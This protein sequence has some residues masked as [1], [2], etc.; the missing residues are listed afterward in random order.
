VADDQTLYYDDIVHNWGV[1]ERHIVSKICGSKGEST[2]DHVIGRVS[3]WLLSKSVHKNIPENFMNMYRLDTAVF[4]QLLTDRH[5]IPSSPILSHAGTNLDNKNYFS[6][7]NLK[8]YEVFSHICSINTYNS[9]VE[10][11]YHPTLQRETTE[12]IVQSFN[13]EIRPNMG[14]R[15]RE[16]GSLF[17]RVVREKTGPK[18][19]SLIY[20]HDLPN[21]DP[22]VMSIGSGKTLGLAFAQN[23]KRQGIFSDAVEAYYTTPNPGYL[24][25]NNTA[26]PMFYVNAPG[27]I[28]TANDFTGYLTAVNKAGYYATLLA[29]LIL[30]QKEGYLHE[31]VMPATLKYRPVGVGIMGLHAAMIKCDV[32]YEGELGIEF[33]SQTQKCLTLGTMAASCKL[34]NL[35][36]KSK[37]IGHKGERLNSLAERC[38]NGIEEG[39]TLSHVDDIKKALGTHGCMYN[40]TTTVQGYDR[41]LPRLVGVSTEGIEPLQSIEMHC[42]VNEENDL[43]L[44]PLEI[45]DARHQMTC[46]MYALK[47]QTAPYISTEYKINLIKTLQSFS[48]SPIASTIVIPTEMSHNRVVALIEDAYN[49]GLFHVKFR[50]GEHSILPRTYNRDLSPKEEQPVETREVEV[51]SDNLP[52]VVP[53]PFD[54]EV[55]KPVEQ[56][57][58]SDPVLVEVTNSKTYMIYSPSLKLR[59]I[60]PDDGQCV[61]IDVLSENEQDTDFYISKPSITYSLRTKNT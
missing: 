1:L 49:A 32:P 8:D 10:V 61:H 12:D 42:T 28:D 21:L 35:S 33:A 24:G 26:C 52:L 54:S 47:E 6:Y 60:I 55:V 53:S 51:F 44:F 34:M 27:I 16:D 43:A 2:Y 13:E 11:G 4:S 36:T 15:V 7:Y 57:T 23:V 29:N 58:T 56:P 40:L 19:R 31:D 14:I 38:M 50:K 25:P 9:G 46:N 30:F 45:F 18:E 3:T 20:Y 59:M 37:R 22:V 41:N 48:H 5:I 39:V 17:E